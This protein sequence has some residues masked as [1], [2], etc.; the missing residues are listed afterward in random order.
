MLT[1]VHFAQVARHKWGVILDK[2]PE[3]S[4][5]EEHHPSAE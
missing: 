2:L 4:A 3:F 1:T 5:L